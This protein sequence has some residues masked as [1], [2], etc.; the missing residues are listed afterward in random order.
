L[1]E[2]YVA[3][4]TAA[5]QERTIDYVNRVNRDTARIAK[6]GE[7]ALY[8]FLFKQT[9]LRAS[10]SKVLNSQGEEE[11]YVLEGFVLGDG[12]SDP[13]SEF[14]KLVDGDFSYLRAVLSSPIVKDAVTGERVQSGGLLTVSVNYNETN[15]EESRFYQKIF[16]NPLEVCLFQPYARMNSYVDIHGDPQHETRFRRKIYDRIVDEQYGCRDEWQ[17]S[18]K[19]QKYDTSTYTPPQSS[20]TGGMTDDMPF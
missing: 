14:D 18:F 1:I 7:V 11:T 12:T 16:T 4:L 2:D 8:D 6:K 20:Q 13:S 10:G 19:F 5:G 17:N 9:S 3:D 15:P